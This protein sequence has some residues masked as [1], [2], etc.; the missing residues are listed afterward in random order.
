[1]NEFSL[2]DAYFKSIPHHRKDVVFGI[3]DDAACLELSSGMQL[4]VS[5][6]TLVEGVHFLSSWDAYDVACRAV[7]VN[8]SDIVAMGGRPCWVTLALTLP[9]FDES[10]LQSFSQGLH[11]ALERYGVALIG[12]D[13]TRGP[14]SITLSI[15]GQVPKGK[16]VR[17]NGALPGDLIYVS[18]GLGGA[19]FAIDRSTRQSRSDVDQAILMEKLLHP[20]PRL[21]LVEAMSSFATA[22]I[23]ISDGLSADLYHICLE[24]HVGACLFL[25]Q[26]PIHPLVKKYQGDKA[27]DFALTGG[28]DYE[29]CFTVSPENEAPLLKH[30]DTLGLS[31]YWIGMIEATQGLRSK[32]LRGEMVTLRPRGYSHF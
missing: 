26:I 16:A 24:S 18:G 1:M 9:L 30:L 20:V 17:R 31:C 14:L 19:A 13:T 23:D 8:V 2:I 10:W 15:H 32:T 25:D 29:L 7:A 28:D 3:G 22:A 11:D 12:G 6:D 4:L 27:L 21:D 5:C